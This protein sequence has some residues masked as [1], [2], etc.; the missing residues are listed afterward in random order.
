[1]NSF[2]QPPSLEALETRLKGRKTETEESLKKRLASAKE[3]MD[4]AHQKGAYDIILINDNIDEAYQKLENYIVHQWG[5][6]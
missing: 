4:Y 6:V 1:M 5:K 3:S 2:I